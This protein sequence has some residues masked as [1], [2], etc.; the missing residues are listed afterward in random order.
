MPTVAPEAL[1]DFV[2]RLF[3]AAGAPPAIA[4]FVA[5]SLVASDLAGHESHGV[6]RVIQ[7]LESIDAGQLLPAA[8]P[9][10]ERETPT[11]AV[12]DGHWGFGQVTARFAMKTAIAKAQAQGIAA[13]G[14]RNCNHIGRVGEWTQMAAERQMIGLGFCNGGRP[15]GAVAP[16]GGRARLLGTNP[17]AA[18]LPVAGQ[19]PLV[20]DF[21]TSVVA[22]GKIRIAHHR[23][24]PLPEGWILGPEGEPSTDARD[25]YAGGMLLPAAGHKG[26]GLS[27]LMEFLGGI[28]A[29]RG[30][31]AL[32]GFVTGNGVLFIALAIEP[33]RRLEDFLND[34]AALCA[35]A[36]ATPPAAGHAEVFLPGEP[37]RRTTA[38]RQAAGVVID[39]TTWQELMDAADRR[40]VPPGM[41]G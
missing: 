28:L 24:K 3:V 16:Y 14:V 11:T 30:C 39:T 35:R 31:P 2:Q 1:I 20:I 22:E 4:R 26:Y 38:L 6:V 37:E 23:G 19:P 33:F 9:T 5:E 10:I 41:V 13:V 27:M 34:A 21:A 40:H 12:V 25:F 32:P 29:G 17:I 36:K 18:A 8:E 15:G 7:Y